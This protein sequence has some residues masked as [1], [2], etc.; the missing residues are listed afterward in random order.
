MSQN[1]VLS[2][3]NTTMFPYDGHVTGRLVVKSKCKIEPVKVKS[4]LKWIVTREVVEAAKENEKITSPSF[5]VKLP[6][7][8]STWE[9]AICINPSENEKKCVSLFIKCTKVE[10]ESVKEVAIDVFLR[11]DILRGR[12]SNDSVQLKSFAD[13][14]NP[15]VCIF[16]DVQEM[17]EN[18]KIT[19]IV[20]LRIQDIG[21]MRTKD[22]SKY[23][24]RDMKAAADLAPLSDF[25]IICNGK[26]FLCH[27]VILAS[28]SEVFK[29]MVLNETEEKAKNKVGT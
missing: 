27:K 8:T 20:H 23:W 28:K 12:Y 16:D 10:D 15:P 1:K 29:A 6:G 5:K 4:Q 9:L 3:K 13:A 26:E 24:I 11:R 25:T 19:I 21:G 14:D 18:D 2:V 17:L 22:V 7:E